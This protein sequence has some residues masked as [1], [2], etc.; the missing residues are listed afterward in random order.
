MA[1]L[2]RF[3]A[4]YTVTT[5]EYH[6]RVKRLHQKHGDFVR[7]GPRELDICNVNAINPLFGAKT[8]CLKGP[9]YERTL[10]GGH[11]RFLQNEKPTGHLWKRRIW[12]AG[13]NSNSI[14]TY[15]PHVLRYIDVL[16]K[17]LRERSNGGK[18]IDLGLYMSFFTFDVMGEL[19]SVQRL[20]FDAFSS[21][22]IY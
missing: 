21:T 4:T 11:E 13:L 8:T 10:M 1:G 18:V 19:G 7:V 22:D 6:R 2:T 15:E 14:R 5:G 20:G 3:W 12:E 17:A 9:W 16:T